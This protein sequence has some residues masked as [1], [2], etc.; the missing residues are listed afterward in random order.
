MGKVCAICGEEIGTKDGENVCR[1]CEDNTSKAKR[2]K[3]RANRKARESVLRDCGLVKV[4]GAMGG[5]YWE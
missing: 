2:A 1:T 5:T 4:R 3:A